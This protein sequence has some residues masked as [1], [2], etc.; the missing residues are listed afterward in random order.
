MMFAGKCEGVGAMRPSAPKKPF[1]H[2]QFR[3]A[4]NLLEKV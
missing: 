1:N 4:D 2:G 3:L